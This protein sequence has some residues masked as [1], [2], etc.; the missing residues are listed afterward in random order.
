MKNWHLS[1][2]TAT[3]LILEIA[4]SPAHAAGI[5]FLVIHQPLRMGEK[6]RFEDYKDTEDNGTEIRSAKFRESVSA[7]SFWRL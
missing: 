3:L 1:F 2:M 7:K 4:S 5:C 6:F